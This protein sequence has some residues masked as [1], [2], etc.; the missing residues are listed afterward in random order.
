LTPGRLLLA[1][2]LNGLVSVAFP[3]SA[4]VLRVAGLTD[5]QYG[6][7]FLPQMSLAAAGALGAAFVLKRV[8]ARRGL[9]LGYSLMALSQTA[10]AAV[11]FV[12]RS[13]VYPL[14]L[15]GTSLL[16]L[17]AGVSAGPLN[18]YPQALFPA[19]AESA[20]VAL[21][22]V[23]GVGLAVTPVVAGAAIE[24]GAWIALP[25]LLA[26]ASLAVSAGLERLDPVEPEPPRPPA[27]ARAGGTPLWLFVGIALCYGMTEAVFGNWGVVYV[28][29]ER[30]LGAAAAGLA[31]TAFWAS[32]TGSRLA[33]AA[34]LL[35]LEPTRV[36][37]ALA[38]AMATACLLVP[39]AGTARASVL[40]FA[41]AGLGCSAVFPLAVGLAGRR[42][43]AD[44]TRVSSA[45][46]AAL[47]GGQAVGSF[48]VGVLH[49]RLD[50][51]T[52]YALAALPPAA[53]VLLARR[54]GRECEDGRRGAAEGAPPLT[55]ATSRPSR[56]AGARPG[57]P[58]A[59]GGRAAPPR[60]RPRSRWRA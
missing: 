11:P 16:G 19:R 49:A 21:H 31:V 24:R 13:A 17:G 39:L 23:I 8:G 25:L 41:A 10:L 6:S 43:P 9:V 55:D 4:A 47:V 53:A 42:F 5:A 1:C 60:R 7:I 59:A 18:A 51:A 48:S 22:T 28:T 56:A 57:G 37:P 38:A 12:A 45:L 32:L 15:A 58:R 40:V 44:R 3:S 36:L 14:A 30:G 26:V 35:R 54:A 34:L 46:F 27:D 52:I 50:L 29:E 33:V 2:F 20:V